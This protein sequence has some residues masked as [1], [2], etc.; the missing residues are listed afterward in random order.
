M[1]TLQ[2]GVV[3]FHPHSELFNPTFISVPVSRA[4]KPHVQQ[5]RTFPSEEFF[6]ELQESCPRRGG[7][8]IA[9]IFPAATVFVV[10]SVPWPAGPGSAI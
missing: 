5:M 6:C 8:Y 3:N 2:T 4:S 7:A 9:Y 1:I 10:G